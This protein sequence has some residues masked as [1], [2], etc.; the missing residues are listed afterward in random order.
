MFE[1]FKMIYENLVKS[2]KQVLQQKD[3]MKFRI[4]NYNLSNN[5]LYKYYGIYKIRF[6]TY[7]YISS[8]VCILYL[9]RST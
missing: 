4:K 2:L 6:F 3:C 7:L 8:T 1:A 9:G 5:T